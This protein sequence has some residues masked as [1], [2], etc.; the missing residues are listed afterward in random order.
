VSVKREVE[1]PRCRKGRWDAGAKTVCST[2][3]DPILSTE[4]EAPSGADP[5]LVKFLCPKCGDFYWIHM[6]SLPKGFVREADMYNFWHEE[7]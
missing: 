3:L 4:A 6:S 7:P 5:G 1:I 2:L